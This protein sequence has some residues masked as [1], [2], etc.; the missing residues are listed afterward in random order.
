MADKAESAPAANPWTV[1]PASQRLIPFSSAM[2]RADISHLT[3][4]SHTTART[5]L[6]SLP[7]AQEKFACSRFNSFFS[8]DPHHPTQTSKHDFDSA[9]FPQIRHVHL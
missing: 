6:K 4:R 8:I 7:Q 9:P 1:A 3:S 5:L 2:L